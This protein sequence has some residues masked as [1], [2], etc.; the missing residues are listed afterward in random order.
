MTQLI[1]LGQP[2]EIAGT[3]YVISALGPKESPLGLK[4][5]EFFGDEL[6]DLER[7]VPLIPLFTRMVESGNDDNVPNY[8][9]LQAAVKEAIALGKKIRG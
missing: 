6:H 2:V 5:Q 9:D 1:Y 3:N 8:E 7:S 4:R